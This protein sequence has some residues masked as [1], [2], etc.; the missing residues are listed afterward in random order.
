M[1]FSEKRK[2]IEL[3]EEL[4][5]LNYK[6]AFILNTISEKEKRLLL[7]NFY[8]KLHKQKLNFIEEIEDKIE[9]IKKEISPT[10]DPKLLSFYRKKKYE[11]S[12]MY[13]KYKMKYKYAD[14]YKREAKALKTY[15]TDL[16]KIN[17]A[18]VREI[19]LAH[20]HKIKTNI[21]EMNATGIRKFPI[22]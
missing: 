15:L 5:L 8:K 6:S 18:G 1:K 17:H 2:T 4:R 20:K 16:S 3:L 13:L 14:A 10:A 12:Q 7:R 9:Q 11:F 19:L 21:S 22:S